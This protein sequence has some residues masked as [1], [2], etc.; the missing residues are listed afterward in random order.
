MGQKQVKALI[1]HCGYN[2]VI[3]SIYKGKPLIGNPTT[4]DQ[5]VNC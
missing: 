5:P 2:S 4:R 1:T 3:E